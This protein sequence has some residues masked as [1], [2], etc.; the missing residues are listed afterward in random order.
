MNKFLIGTVIQIPFKEQSS[1]TKVA[2]PKAP[3]KRMERRRNSLTLGFRQ[4]EPLQQEEKQ[5]TKVLRT[6]PVTSGRDLL[7]RQQLNTTTE[8]LPIIDL[9]DLASMLMP[10]K[11]VKHDDEQEPPRHWVQRGGARSRGGGR[12]A[13]LLSSSCV[14]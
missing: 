9:G 2:A 4:E 6:M 12:E 1:T 7:L 10:P 14:F 8:P 11:V 13:A 5:E 3:G